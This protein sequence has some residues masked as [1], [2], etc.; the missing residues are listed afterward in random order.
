MFNFFRGEKGYENVDAGAFQQMVK[1]FPDAVIIDVRTGREFNS[2]HL[3]RAEH[4]D[5]YQNFKKQ[6]EPLPRDKKYLLYC[7]SGARS[8]N[9][10]RIMH[11]MGFTDLTNFKGGILAWPGIVTHSS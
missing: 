2:G 5:F 3:P 6:V 9:A 8:A 7:R 4:K 10:C 1:D 11:R